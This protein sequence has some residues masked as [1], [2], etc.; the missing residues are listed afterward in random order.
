MAERKPEH[1]CRCRWGARHEPQRS[2][3]G[4]TPW[5]PPVKPGCIDEAG[6]SDRGQEVVTGRVKAR[7]GSND[8]VPL[9]DGIGRK[10][11][12]GARPFWEQIA[13]PAI[14]PVLPQATRLLT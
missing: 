10:C 11:G 3:I 1:S 9:E 7:L 12:K 2:S 13:A 5:W 14:T 6:C 4:G 8:G